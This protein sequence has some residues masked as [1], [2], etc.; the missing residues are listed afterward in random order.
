MFIAIE[1]SFLLGGRAINISPLCG[2]ARSQQHA[3]TLLRGPA[4]ATLFLKRIHRNHSP[5]PHLR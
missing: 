2:Q 5:S 1:G 3:I 4:P